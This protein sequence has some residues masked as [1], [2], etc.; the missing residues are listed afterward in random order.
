MLM[1]TTIKHRSLLQQ[2]ALDKAVKAAQKSLSLDADNAYAYRNLALCYAQLGATEACC[3]ALEQGSQAKF[4]LRL[5]ETIA[6]M[7]AQY[8]Q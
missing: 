7:Q 1:P 4:R 6:Q 8:C 2:G 3:K 5:Q